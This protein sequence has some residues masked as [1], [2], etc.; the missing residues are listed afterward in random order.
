MC[1][2]TV[3]QEWKEGDGIRCVTYYPEADYHRLRR[4]DQMDFEV[5]STG[6][7]PN[8][9]C[10]NFVDENDEVL[11]SGFGRKERPRVIFRVCASRWSK[12]REWV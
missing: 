1:S 11:L 3:D 5:D 12:C 10:L 9:G 2:S 4:S 7:V 6:I 8:D